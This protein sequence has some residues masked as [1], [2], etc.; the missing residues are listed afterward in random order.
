MVHLNDG[1]VF[2]VSNIPYENYLRAFDRV[3][4]RSLL[5]SDRFI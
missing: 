1:A 5:E 4:I 3:R 2:F